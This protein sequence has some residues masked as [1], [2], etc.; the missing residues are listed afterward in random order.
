MNS[1]MSDSDS[2]SDSDS[3]SF[4][5]CMIA[6]IP[7]SETRQIVAGQ[8]VSDI[9]ST[10]KELVDNALDAGSKAI[11]IKLFN[12]GIDKIEVSDD[13]CG[14]PTHSRPLVA[15]KHAT[16]KLR[17]FSSLYEDTYA[18][19]KIEKKQLGFRGEALF[20]MA[21][22]SQNLIIMTQTQD[23][24]IG[25]ELEFRHDG[26]LNHSSVRDVQ[27]KIGTTV[28][29]VKLFNSL[30]VRRADLIKRIKVQ[31]ANLFKL[32][33]AYAV[34]CVGVRFNV[35]DIT[36]PVGSPKCKQEVKLHTSE[37]SKSVKETVSAVFGSKFL[38]GMC[39]IEVDL[40]IAVSKARASMKGASN[41]AT[42][43]VTE[44]DSWRI[45][46][47]VSRAPNALNSGKT[48]RDI[49][50]FSVNGRPVECPQIAKTLSSVWRNF[51]SSGMGGNGVGQKKRPAC[52][53]C[54]NLPSSMFDINLAPDK[55]EILLTEE[56]TICELLRDKLNN[57]WTKHTGG[58]FE[59]NEVETQSNMSEP[60]RKSIVEKLPLENSE[61]VVDIEPSNLGRS[62]MRRRNAC[63]IAF[64]NIGSKAPDTEQTSGELDGI[65]EAARH[66]NAL[67]SSFS[68]SENPVPKSEDE[69]LCS[70]R[71]QSQTSAESSILP[72]CS[73]V[74]AVKCDAKNQ[75]QDRRPN[76][77]EHRSWADAAVKFDAKNQLL[78]RRTNDGEH[79]AWEDAKFSFNSSGFNSQDDDIQKLNPP[80]VK[81]N[82]L[83]PAQGK[84]D[85]EEAAKIREIISGFRKG[86]VPDVPIEPPQKDSTSVKVA[87]KSSSIQS[88][89]QFSFQ[90]SAEKVNAFVSPDSLAD[91]ESPVSRSGIESKARST[92]V[93]DD[94]TA[95]NSYPQDFA[96]K[97]PRAEPISASQALA[98]KQFDLETGSDT[99]LERDE[100][101]SSP[102]HAQTLSAGIGKKQRMEEPSEVCWDDFKG[103]RHIVE[104]AQASRIEM[105]NT[106]K[107]LHMHSSS[108]SS[109]KGASGSKHQESSIEIDLASNSNTVS[110]SK[111]EFIEMTIIGQFNLGFI[112]AM[113]KNNHLWILDQHACD[114]KY[115]FEKIF[116]ETKVHEQ[117]LIAPLPLELSPSEEN[118]VVENMDIFEQNGFRFHFDGDKP[119]RHRLSLTAL[120]HSGSG[121]DG[122]KA[123]QFGKEDVG[124]LCAILGADGAS[125]SSGYIAGS[126]TGAD[127]GGSMGN[128]AVRRYAGTGGTVIRL[129]K[130]VAM[131]ASRA[132]RSS[133]MIGDSLSK[134]EME[135]IVH[136]LNNLDQP[137]DCPHG[138]P[139]I[140]HVKNMIENIVHDEDLAEKRVTG[141]SLAVMDQ[142]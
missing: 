89:K 100:L 108:N 138:R 103:T 124:A 44:D 86:I 14:I 30:P 70:K 126:G 130:A 65:H 90:P 129:P 81:D 79:R 55:R 141:P 119:V 7:E 40:S 8:A 13:G 64:D 128:N 17:T 101:D 71:V 37:R 84:E 133:I 35:V 5:E 9:A 93:Q 80:L 99:P 6:P 122:R 127:G 94:S 107:H 117:N 11:K 52:I 27:R 63:Y 73:K 18:D 3:E 125:S 66:F 62:K 116:A 51:D 142:D 105:R 19:G 134:K 59:A 23:D 56:I 92:L 33:Q 120:P 132:C 123:V 24:M 4:V 10:V 75:P 46:G 67:N 82:K 68:S 74:A 137:W 135:Q 28:T 48:A 131:F 29:V 139:T 76:D 58:K 85:S 45:E 54:L 47:L 97:R 96:R 53:L 34:L 98:K 60:S 83:A 87:T 115:N 15:M 25:Q 69:K 102:L 49:Q 111:E 36:G 50:F 21:N 2:D 78:N 140:R 104:L 1:N 121:G 22:V 39:P 110:L 38:A 57:I 118:C 106:R 31:R 91:Y 88:I 112:L 114:E 95:F 77:R 136:R 20:S 41:V 72:F 16:S 109:S 113:C 61:Q 32:M 12:Q 26:Y 42:N 43:V